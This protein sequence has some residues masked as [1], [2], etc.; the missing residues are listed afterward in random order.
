MG[1]HNYNNTTINTVIFIQAC[2]LQFQN[3]TFH[4]LKRTVLTGLVSGLN[5]EIDTLS[6]YE[7]NV[8]LL[9]KNTVYKSQTVRFKREKISISSPKHDMSH[10]KTVLKRKTYVLKPHA[11]A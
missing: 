3:C 7:R 4:V 5:N 11:Q 2:G 8:W 10:G 6:R 1:Y 9:Y